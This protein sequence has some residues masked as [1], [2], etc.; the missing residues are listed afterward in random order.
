MSRTLTASDRRSLIRLASTM[1]VGSPERKAILARVR[2]ASDPL[3]SSVKDALKKGL[4]IGVRQIGS[5]TVAPEGIVVE[6]TVSVVVPPSKVLAE[7]PP[8]ET[9]KMV[10]DKPELL[11]DVP[12]SK[13]SDIPFRALKPAQFKTFVKKMGGL[14]QYSDEVL[15]ALLEG[16]KAEIYEPQDLYFDADPKELASYIGGA[17]GELNDWGGGEVYEISIK[18]GVVTGIGSIPYVWHNPRGLT[19]KRDVPDFP[20]IKL[21]SAVHG[22]GDPADSTHPS[23]AG[24]RWEGTDNRPEYLPKGTPG[25]VSVDVQI[26]IDLKPTPLS[27]LPRSELEML[28]QDIARDS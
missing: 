8:K 20:Y 5:Y 7:A 26:G 25:V 12:E 28:V 16:R 1:P 24:L 9:L 18:G 14:G 6:T 19:I 27:S 23:L 15:R 13:I 17:G 11:S 3:V 21:D 10:F 4:Y 2:T 22:P